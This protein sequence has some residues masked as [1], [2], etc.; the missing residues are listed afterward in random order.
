MFSPTPS[1]EEHI[2][3]KK[4]NRAHLDGWLWQGQNTFFSGQI[5]VLFFPMLIFSLSFL[6]S[7]CH[8]S[9]KLPLGSRHSTTFC[10]LLLHLSLFP[11][12]SCQNPSLGFHL[13]LVKSSHLPQ[14]VSPAG[15]ALAPSIQQLLGP[16]FLEFSTPSQFLLT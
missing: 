9:L 11:S 5:W 8:I 15:P 1:P 13:S 6:L 14:V 2:V 10:S 4:E 3:I 16:F 7:E 12:Y